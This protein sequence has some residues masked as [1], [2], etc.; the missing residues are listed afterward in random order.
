MLPKGHVY[1][2]VS[3]GGFRFVAVVSPAPKL[4]VFHRLCWFGRTVGRVSATVAFC[5]VLSESVAFD[6]CWKG[7]AVSTFVCGCSTYYIRIPFCG[8]R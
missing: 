5:A 3:F 8:F 6:T 7:T 4:A 2:G 1:N